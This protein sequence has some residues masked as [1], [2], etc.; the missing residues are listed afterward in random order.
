MQH[1]PEVI[2]A[3][4]GKLTAGW[5]AT[6]RLDDEKFTDHNRRAHEGRATILTQWMV[7]VMAEVPDLMKRLDDER[8]P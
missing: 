1:P 4:L 2:G 5:L 6:Y 7:G 8:K 3:A